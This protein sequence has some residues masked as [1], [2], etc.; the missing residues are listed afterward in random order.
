MG[1]FEAIVLGVVQGLSEFL[2]ISSSGHL[3]VFQN[4][5]TPG[6]H[7]IVFDLA[8][9]VGTVTSILTL[10]A[11]SLIEILRDSF[12]TV[13]TKQPTHGFKL[14]LLIVL[15]N[16]PTAIIG[17]GFK[18]TFEEMFSS[19]TTVAICFSITGFLL[20]QTRGK[21]TDSDMQTT[22]MKNLEG[23]QTLT[24]SRALFIGLAQGMA[25]AP[26][27]SRSGSTIAAAILSGVDRKIAA[28]FSFMMSIP[29]ILGASI[30]ELK[31]V[32]MENHVVWPILIAGFT[33]AYLSGLF[34][35]AVVLRF[36]KK[37]RLEIFSYYLWMLSAF[38]LVKKFLL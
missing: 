18:D 23:M 35:L 29:A 4:I 38:I 16:I 3:V 37:G 28:L 22:D 7:S 6:P 27:I 33:A 13:R 9:H 17:F 24:W 1:F 11:R 5:L 32:S 30:I 26:G 36:V 10:Y 20:W 8:V 25:I 34:G 2:P 19:L 15:A 31:D 14:V 21:N 12:H